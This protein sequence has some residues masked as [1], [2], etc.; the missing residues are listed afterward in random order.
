M[1]TIKHQFNEKLDWIISGED[2]ED[3]VFRARAVAQMDPTFPQFIRMACVDEERITGIPEGVPDT[4]KLEE[5]L[6]DGIADTTLR[7]ELRRIRNF[8]ARG[9]MQKVPLARRESMWIQMLE[10]VH[11][12]E[13]KLLTAIKDRT[14]FYVYPDLFD[15]MKE[16]TG[17]EVGLPR[18]E[19]LSPKTEAPVSV[20][21]AA[22]DLNVEVTEPELVSIPKPKRGRKPKGSIT[23]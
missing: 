13:A 16:I 20:T 9:E 17:Q 4:L 2:F 11:Y 1:I 7:Q 8:Q 5:D 15:I 14:L 18:P 3:K 19:T 12:K 22:A 23:E 21:G 6:P 10:S